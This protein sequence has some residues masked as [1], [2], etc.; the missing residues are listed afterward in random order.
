M[1]R[2][3][4][5]RGANMLV[6][7]AAN[8]AMLVAT[9]N[10]A[11]R[12]SPAFDE[13]AHFASGLILAKH[14]DAGYF[15]VN[16]PVSR[17]ITAGATA[18]FPELSLPPVQ[19]STTHTNTRRPEFETG[20]TVLELNENNYM[21]ALRIARLARLP[22][23]VL[24]AWLLWSVTSTLAPTRRMLCVTLWC[25]SP[26]VLG[27]GWVLSADALAGVAM[28]F[29]LWN[30]QRLWD[31]PTVGNFSLA[32]IGWG[33]AVGTKF[34]FGPL[35]L[36]YPLLVH[37]CAPR[38]WSGQTKSRSG[39]HDS[40]CEKSSGEQC[41]SW[42]KLAAKVSV[43]WGILAA[44][45]CLTV[46][47]LYLCDETAKPLGQHDFVSDLFSKWTQPDSPDE[48]TPPWFT[49]A[50]RKVPSPFPR[51]LLEGV[52]KQLADMDQP[53][54]AYL[55]G[56]RIPGEIPW[57]FLVGYFI[58][59]QLAV[60]LGGLSILLAAIWLRTR[61]KG[62]ERPQ[63]PA[64]A[65]FCVLYL[66]GFSL[67]MA[68]QYNLVWN[69]R[70]LIPALPMLYVVLAAF[71]PKFDISFPW[72]AKRT[73]SDAVPVSMV[74]IAFLEFVSVFPFFFSYTSP[75]LGGS[76]RVPMALNDSNF[77]YGQDLF[78]IR[79]WIDQQNRIRG[80]EDSLNTYGILS[81]HGRGW[82]ADCIQ[83][84]DA[85]MIEALGQRFEAGRGL[86]RH[87]SGEEVALIL[88]RGLMHPQQWAVRYSNFKD[89]NSTLA[90]RNRVAEVQL[91]HRPDAFITPT[92]A[93]YYIP[94]PE[95]ENAGQ[96]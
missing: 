5:T 34:T 28:C 96:E 81:G 63:R 24:A 20:D 84:A 9:A 70:Y 76:Y 15:R 75:L 26:L 32:G 49:R 8:V 71:I 93:V 43:R 41:P 3:F 59:E 79:R 47:L 91:N 1:N 50:M 95:A 29:I 69:I 74:A 57:F 2:S 53:H 16:P 72:G 46:N 11:L 42:I 78:Y 60:W 51:V 18:V 54:G 45:G 12:S 65:F 39:T 92:L 64:I 80:A 94:A 22:F 52:D 38:A 73:L 14:G 35:A 37:F 48:S 87:E 86:R 67:L 33:L 85:Q 31:R 62:R 61:G 21:P 82:L 6:L 27:H 25:T 23:L 77:D 17:W 55:A 4:K 90:D 83:P 89:M 68:N 56:H 40:S 88:S 19:P 58:K 13:P 10:S 66:L 30:T 44:V 7:L 36:L